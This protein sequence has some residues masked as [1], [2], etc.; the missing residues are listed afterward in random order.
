MVANIYKLYNLYKTMKNEETI[1]SAGFTD[2]K[3]E[4]TRVM[5]VEGEQK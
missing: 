5:F 3:F 2:G 1:I 4:I